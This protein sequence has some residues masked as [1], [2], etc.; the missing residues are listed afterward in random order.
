MSLATMAA[1][2]FENVRHASVLNLA[3]W[4]R[5]QER[6]AEHIAHLTLSM[7]RHPPMTSSVRR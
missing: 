3:H 7:F 5:F 2:I 6:R 1:P 4:Y